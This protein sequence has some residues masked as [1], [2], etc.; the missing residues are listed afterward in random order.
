MENSKSKEKVRHLFE[1]ILTVILFTL[2]SIVYGGWAISVM[3]IP[4]LPYLVT[5]ITGHPNLERDINLLFFAREFIVGRIIALIGFMVLFLAGMQ[6]I[7]G[8]ARGVGLIKTG[9]YSFVRH[10][11]YAGIIIITIG[12]TVMALTLGSNPQITLLWL[13][14]V[15]GYIVLAGYEESHLEK[16][17]E[18]NFR[19]YKQNVP[20]IFSIKCSSKIPEILFTILIAVI[21]S[22]VFLTFP[23]NLIRI[24]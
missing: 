5:L 10:P 9:V 16:Q 22:F 15:L 11:Q 4:L 24:H 14:Q 7:R 21:I 8:H 19:Q 3:S 23:F 18:E 1:T 12:L 6:L 17:Y 2:Q 20:F 13:I